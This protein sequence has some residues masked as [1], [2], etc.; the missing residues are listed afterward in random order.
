MKRCYRADEEPVKAKHCALGGHSAAR[1]G[2]GP[3]GGCAPPEDVAFA[4]RARPRAGSGRVRRAGRRRRQRGQLEGAG[5][6]GRGGP[7]SGAPG[8]RGSRWWPSMTRWR[9]NPRVN[10]DP[11]R[12]ALGVMAHG[13]NPG[14]PPRS[15]TNCF[16]TMKR[17]PS[18][19]V[20]GTSIIRGQKYR[21]F[22]V[23]R[24]HCPRLAPEN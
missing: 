7:R 14:K 4:D 22:N 17:T 8:G 19:Q 5:A 2:S 20:S 13:C 23:E 6:D 10:T 16:R 11:L 18:P 1:G 24:R 15:W 12:A 9:S 3:A 21:V